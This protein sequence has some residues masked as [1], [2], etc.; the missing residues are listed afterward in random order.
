MQLIIA[1]KAIAGSR[2]ASIL[3]GRPVELV[4]EGAAQLLRFEA[5]GKQFMVIPLR[6]H[7]A[8]V[9]FPKQYSYWGGT[10]LKDLTMA[11]L[12]YV[13]TEIGIVNLLRQKSREAD[14]VIIATDADREGEAIGV[15]A[16]QYLQQTNPNISFSRAYFSAMT[17]KDIKTAF[18][19]LGKVDFD[20]ADSANARRE[21]DLIWGAVLTRFISMASN[22]RGKD[23]LSVGRVQ[24]PVLTLL[25]DREKERRAFN[26]QKYWVV[27]AVFEKNGS[28]FEAEHK[29]GKFWKK[30]E[31]QRVLEK[32]TNAGT[33][34]RV[35]EKKRVLERPLP[36]NTTSFLRAASALGLQAGEAMT[37]AESLYQSGYTSYPRTD[38]QAYP[39][40]LD[41]NEILG[42]LAKVSSFAPLV[43]KIRKLGPLNPSKGPST[44]DHPPVHP[45]SA[46]P[47]EKLSSKQWAVYELIGRR[48]LATLADDAETLNV[49]VEIDLNSE[50]F[51]AL[52]Q[53][54]LKLGWKE[55]YP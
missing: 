31:A 43:Q 5:D 20:F 46:A 17:P 40:N 16:L 21:I 27:L 52:G 25:V 1:E 24:T 33:V 39:V 48:F 29:T 4:R 35:L 49:R 23:F 32:K 53:T 28:K 42:E 51:V 3:A 2:I 41:L 30:E 44:K 22:R 47:R 15:E 45:V 34:T 13:P 18:S 55:Y 36:F 9:D 10:H 54:I 37:I 19:E 14:S 50:P 11:P 7:I 8:D 12:E 26:Q 38:N 6:G